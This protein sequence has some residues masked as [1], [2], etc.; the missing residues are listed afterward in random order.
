MGIK[1]PEVKV[2]LIGQDGNAFAILGRVG[3]AMREAGVCRCSIED[4]QKEA[5][6]GDYQNLLRVVMDYVNVESEE[7][8]E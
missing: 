1:Y 3:A 6:S 2:Q 8:D 7:E 4:F 5:M